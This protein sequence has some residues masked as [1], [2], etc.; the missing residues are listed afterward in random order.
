MLL[1]SGGLPFHD[2]YRPTDEEFDRDR[3]EW[4]LFCSEMPL[5]CVASPGCR[6]T[7]RDVNFRVLKSVNDIMAEPVAPK[8]SIGI[9]RRGTTTNYD[10]SF[11]TPA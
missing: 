1:Y 11:N 2:D 8:Y 7:S 4:H 10:H 6:V 9:R 5:R 3:T